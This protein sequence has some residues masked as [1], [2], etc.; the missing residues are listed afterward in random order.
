MIIDRKKFIKYLTVS[1]LGIQSSG[2]GRLFSRSDDN[3]PMEFGWTT[4]LTY[5]TGNRRLSFEY[6][7]HLLEEMNANGM[8]RLIVMMA[9]HGYFD[10]QNHGLAWPVK[11]KKLI[12]Q[13]DKNAVNAYEESEFFSKVITR[14]KKLNIKIQIE[15]KYLGMIGI[16]EG[17]PGVEFLRTKEGNII[18]TIRPEA[19]DYERR[20]IE[21]LHICCDS[22]QA[23][24][25]MR[26]KITD[27]LTRYKNLDGIVLEHPSYS[28]DNT[29]YCKWSRE[30]VKKDTGKNIEDLS[31]SELREWKSLRIKERLIDLKRLI[32][33]INPKFEFGFYTGF[34]PSDGNIASFQQ[35]RGHQTETIKEVGLD[36]VMPYCEGRH[37]EHETEE[38]EKVI[39]YL[40]PLDFY[41]HTTIRRDS[42]HNYKLPPKGPDYIK[43]IIRWGLQYRNQNSR[44]KGMMFFNEVKI[45]QENRDAV[46]Q[47]IKD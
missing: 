25:Y 4:C 10:P 35:N 18:H 19:S 8:T 6:Y 5:E 15:I 24:L 2:F 33:S 30:R 39:N 14:A 41:L 36:F 45:P 26:D 31:A 16:E 23:H 17:Y 40:A 29:C 47:F 43:N 11:N 46:Y 9:S 37:K 32:K 22:P 42:P 1:L 34:S 21:S 20:A 7:N 44:F 28:G 13:L 38:I 12:Y 3:A 27:V